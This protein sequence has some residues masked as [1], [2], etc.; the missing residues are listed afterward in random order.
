MNLE[1]FLI[2]LDLTAGGIW[3]HYIP[4]SDTEAQSGRE[5]TSVETL[6]IWLIHLNCLP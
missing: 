5:G 6:I 3:L 1:V 2:I 4:M